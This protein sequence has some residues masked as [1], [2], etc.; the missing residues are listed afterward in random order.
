MCSD[1]CWL[2]TMT[3]NLS[4][5]RVTW[6]GVDTLLTGYRKPW[7][8]SN[9]TRDREVEQVSYVWQKYMLSVGGSWGTL[10]QSCFWQCCH[11]HCLWGVE[12]SRKEVGRK[13]ERPCCLTRAAEYVFDLWQKEVLLVFGSRND[14]YGLMWLSRNDNRNRYCVIIQRL[15][16]L[17]E[18]VMSGTRNFACGI[19]VFIDVLQ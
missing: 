5:F 7:L 18:M 10:E 8:L 15:L 11:Q 9:I 6:P 12:F 16:M 4:E 3:H 13:T 2:V 1:D 14:M 19:I 17:I